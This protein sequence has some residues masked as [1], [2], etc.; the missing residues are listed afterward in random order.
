MSYQRQR[1]WVSTTPDV[2]AI[3][4]AETAGL[5]PGT[6]VAVSVSYNAGAAPVYAAS[7]TLTV[8]GPT[9][10][11][12]TPAYG[13]FLTGTVITVLRLKYFALV[14]SVR[15]ALCHVGRRT[16]L[17]QC[18]RGRALRPGLWCIPVA[19]TALWLHLI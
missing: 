10:S 4:D 5:L 15:A 19:L 2:A 18:D 14:R 3:A 12:V 16:A 13:I 11:G 6:G 8:A 7:Q 9:L 17:A 1:P